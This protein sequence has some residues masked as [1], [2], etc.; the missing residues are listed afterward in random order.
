MVDLPAGGHRLVT[1]PSAGFVVQD[2]TLRPEAA[3]AAPR[4]REVT[5]LD[6]N[7]TDRRVRV[8]AGGA[9]LLVVPENANAGWTATVDG[10]PLA[11]TRVDGWQ[12]AWVLPAGGDGEVRL[13]FAPDRTYRG[14]LAAGAV[15]A[16]GV[17]LLAVLPV[18]RRL[19][20]GSVPLPAG[21][22]PAEGPAWVAGVLLVVLLAALGGVL[23]VAIVLAAMLL[24]QLARRALPVVVFGAL[25]VATVTAV[26]G[27][28][29]GHG[30]EWA[31]GPWVQGAM[32][33]AVGAVVAAVLP[34]PG[35]PATGPVVPRA[36]TGGTDPDDVTPGTQDGR[37][38]AATDRD[39]DGTVA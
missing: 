5:V 31:Y 35:V 34:V 32:L 4:H 30:Q 8:A 33:V 16:L 15:M 13:V 12:Q 24:R 38:A 23:P 14:G 37:P 1:S 2:A 22:V 3:L 27:R 25:T 19:A 21:A 9:A 28:L 36:R 29:Q 18:R 11:A 7:P 20:A 17:L 10:R 26:I 39:E 6:W